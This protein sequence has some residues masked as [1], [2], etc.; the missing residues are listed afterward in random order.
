M[1]AFD[2]SYFEFVRTHSDSNELE[3][4][5]SAASVVE[6]ERALGFEL[7]PSYKEFIAEINGGELTLVRLFGVQRDEYL[8]LLTKISEM[9]PFIPEV[10]SKEMVPFASD[11]GGGL[12]CFKI[13]QMTGTA[14]LEVWAWN[15]EYSE[16]PSDAALV[17][18]R[19]AA[20]F[21]EFIKKQV[22]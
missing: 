17:W 13:Q 9:S 22:G 11:W 3:P 5:A 19:V 15:H 4:G 10:K 2:P 12:Y 16:E 18:S 6:V 14:E 20:D 7:P 1:S 21:A 8:D